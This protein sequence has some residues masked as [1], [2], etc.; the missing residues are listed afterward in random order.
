MTCL[1]VAGVKHATDTRLDANFKCFILQLVVLI[2]VNFIA[3]L[4]IILEL[5]YLLSPST[6]NVFDLVSTSYIFRS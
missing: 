6:R 4:F 1:S 3:L 5:T 2:F